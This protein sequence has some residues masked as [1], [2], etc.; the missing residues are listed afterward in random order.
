MK[1][2]VIVPRPSNG[3]NLSRLLSNLDGNANELLV[4][5]SHDADTMKISH[6]AETLGVDMP[7][8]AIVVSTLKDEVDSYGGRLSESFVSGSSITAD[9]S[10]VANS[11]MKAAKGDY[12]LL[13]NPGEVCLDH[14]NI[15]RTLN[16]LDSQPHV[17]V[18][19]CPVKIYE[20]G[21]H[22]K[23]V[24]RP[25]ILRR[26]SGVALVG[27]LA[28]EWTP[29][30]D[31]SWL[32]NAGG[33]TFFDHGDSGPQRME[34]LDLKVE[35]AAHVKSTA[36]EKSS[37][38]GI[39][40]AL[41]VARGLVEALPKVSRPKEISSNRLDEI[42]DFTRL[43]PVVGPLRSKK[44]STLGRALAH[45]CRWDEARDAFELGLKDDRNADVLLGYGLSLIVMGG[46]MN[47]MNANLLFVEALRLVKQGTSYG[48]DM[49]ELE[50]ARH[51]VAESTK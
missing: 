4:M 40:R 39:K 22:V 50:M 49:R 16:F 46:D 8:K 27:L 28:E 15:E 2:S 20:Q 10:E 5:L 13:A 26:R 36:G 37:E 30:R 18:V 51:V 14:D 32:M 21:K 33:L 24:M 45:M 42:I 7:R 43:I 35:L 9:F 3:A 29:F 11:M 34:H 38:D 1:L 41:R 19:S 25:K 12:V 17:E 44:N 48:I 31:T 6:E 23:T 47:R